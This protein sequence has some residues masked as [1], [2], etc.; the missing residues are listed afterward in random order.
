ARTDSRHLSKLSDY[1][2]QRGWIFRFSHT[3]SPMP[4]RL[5]PRTASLTPASSAFRTDSA[6]AARD[7]G[8][9]AATARLLPRYARAPFEIRNMLR[10]SVFLDKTRRHSI[11][12]RAAPIVP[13]SLPPPAR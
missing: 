13:A 4:V 1:I 6:R 10:P 8:D 11:N 3:A 7:G 9:T 5:A 2:T 12:N